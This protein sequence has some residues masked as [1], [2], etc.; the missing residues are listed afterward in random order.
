MYD[1]DMLRKARDD[2]EDYYR[3]RAARIDAMPTTCLN[4]RETRVL[5]LLEALEW[6]KQ[7]GSGKCEAAVDELCGLDACE[8]AGFCQSRTPCGESRD[9]GTGD[10]S[11]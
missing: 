5:G 2:D 6:E 1:P 4:C 8:L 9:S 11:S 7:H 10:V 3:E